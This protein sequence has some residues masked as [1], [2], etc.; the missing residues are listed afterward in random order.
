MHSKM[1]SLRKGFRIFRIVEESARIFLR[2]VRVRIRGIKHY[3]GSAEDVCNQIIKDCYDAEKHYFRASNGHF[4]EFYAR[5]FGWCAESLISLG[6]RDEVISTLDYALNVFQNHGIVEQSINPRGEAFTFPN[7]YSPDALAFLIRSLKLAEATALVKKYKVFLNREIQ[8]YY[9]L[10]IDKKTGLVRKDKSFSSMK[11]YSIRMSSCYD[12][13][14]TAML[15][16]DLTELGLDNPFKKW[17][18]KKLLLKNFWS[19]EYFLDDL[20][21]SNIICGDA[22]TL[23]FWS[24]VITDKALLKK[25]INSIR[26]EGLDK[27]FPLKYTKQRFKEQ[28]MI[29]KEWVAGDYERD[30]IWPH[31]GFMFIK[32]VS[33]VDKKL[34]RDYLDEY[35][36]QIKLHKNF[37]EVYDKEGRPFKNFFFHA[38]ESMLWAANYVHLRKI[39]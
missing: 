2:G 28:K 12:N 39:I 20:S 10:V 38:D 5:D 36:K 6:Y 11:D 17:N 4:C 37:L 8:R 24:G 27:P 18:Y 35:E 22:N 29:A 16:N 31:A 30:A 1:M 26:K 33:Q 23:P 13:I 14:M 21:G 32:V 3:L 19:G 15:A 9:D 25:A 7:K 34:A